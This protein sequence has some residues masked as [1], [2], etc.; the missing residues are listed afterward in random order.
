M[1]QINRVK[2]SDKSAEVQLKEEE[3]ERKI[4]EAELSN[5]IALDDKDLEAKE[6]KQLN[7]RVLLCV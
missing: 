1:Q 3:N 4:K 6:K 2:T 5:S 7:R